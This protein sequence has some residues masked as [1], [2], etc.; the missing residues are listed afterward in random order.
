LR[1]STTRVT[2]GRFDRHAHRGDV[3]V[4]RLDL[5][6]ERGER[7][8]GFLA[9]QVEHQPLGVLQRE[10]AV[11]ERCARLEGHAR[12]VARRPDA[13][14]EDLRVRLGYGAEE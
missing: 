11:V 10:Q 12:V 1:S 14:G 2:P 4:A 13:G 7:A 3:G 6:L 8:V 5:F 9:L